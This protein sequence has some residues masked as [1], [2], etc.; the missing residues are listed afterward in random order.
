MNLT[1]KSK[2][3]LFS[4]FISTMI[5]CSTDDEDPGEPTGET[6]E[7]QV[8]LTDAPVD[9][10]NV[11]A[12]FITVAEVKV[13]GIAVE[14]FEK[15]TIK[16]SDL[17]DGSTKLLGNV[18]LEAGTTSSISLVLDHA[19]DASGSGPGSYVVTTSGEKMVLATGTTEINLSDQ[20]EILPTEDNS[21]V[22]DFDLRKTIK[23]NDEGDASFV[24]EGTIENNVRVVNVL[25][26]GAIEG[27]VSNLEAESK[28]VVL[29][30]EEGTFEESEMEENSNG[31][32][33]S[34][35]VSSDLVSS[36]NG[37]FSLNFLEVGAYELHFVS[38]KDEDSDGDLELAGELDVQT[39]TGAELDGIEVTSEST[40]SLDL[41]LGGL[42]GL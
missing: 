10:P 22:I 41:S 36:S 18:D 11:E 33:F 42:L 13:N 40:T 17:T 9:N 2:F 39:S 12:V 4:L 28:V 32:R 26:T 1:S 34:N 30:Y 27:T 35:A 23:A 5:S 21:L 6:Y 38:M 3:F 31:I 24:G 14:G 20:A 8:L 16:V 37:S 15:S 7:T 19:A 29:A 25:N